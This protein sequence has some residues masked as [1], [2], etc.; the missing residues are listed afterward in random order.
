[1]QNIARSVFMTVVLGLASASAASAGDLKL[2]INGGRAT[3]IAQDVTLGQIL[4]EWARVGRTTIVNAEKLIGP[5]M[6]LQLVDRPEREVLDVLL[7]QASGYIAA[8]RPTLVAGASQFDRVM[9]LPVSRGPVGVAAAAPTPQPFQRPMQQP[10]D[11]DEPIE[12]SVINNQPVGNIPA[13]AMPGMPGFQP[14]QNVPAQ[15]MPGQMPG[16]PSPVLTAPRPGMLPAPPQAPPNPY[17]PVAQ[18]G[19]LRPPGG[20]R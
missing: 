16:Q 11:D 19:I 14:T 10:T 8:A 6:T 2:T 4:A 20:G 17:A 5:P 18:P 1:M 7:R 12:P 3:L 13:Q 9:I 15:Q